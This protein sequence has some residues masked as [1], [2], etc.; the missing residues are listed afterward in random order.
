MV[1]LV[2]LYRKPDADKIE[3]F[4]KHYNEVHV[5]LVKKTPG[6]LKVEVTNLSGAPMGEAPYFLMCEMYYESMDSMNAANASPEGKAAG[7]DLM[8]FAMKYVT[9]FWGDVPETGIARAPKAD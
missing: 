8:T 9:L 1:K 6:L 7:R 3:D 4:I 2:A 5:P